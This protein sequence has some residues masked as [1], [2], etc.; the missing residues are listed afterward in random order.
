[1]DVEKYQ[2][3]SSYRLS[4][5]NISNNGYLYFIKKYPEQ[6]LITTIQYDGT[7]FLWLK[8]RETG[9]YKCPDRRGIHELTFVSHDVNYFDK[10]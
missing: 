5:Q 4:V 2:K 6:Q 8:G 10:K 3:D 1:L 7:A 9:W